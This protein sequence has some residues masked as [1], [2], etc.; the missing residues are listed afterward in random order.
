MA[1]GGRLLVWRRGGGA[2]RFF[3]APITS[4]SLWNVYEVICQDAGGKSALV[5][6][7][8]ATE[9]EIDAFRSVHYPSALGDTA[10]HAVEPR[11]PAPRDPMSLGEAQAFVTRLLRRWL[12]SK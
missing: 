3:A 5:S 9:D 6:K 10:R 4:F 1:G 11:K 2:L 7:G 12:D 8:L